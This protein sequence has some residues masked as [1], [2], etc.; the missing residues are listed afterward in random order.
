MSNDKKMG[1]Q[2]WVYIKE[3]VLVIE[4]KD[5]DLRG[6]VRLKG[7]LEALPEKRHG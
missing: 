6:V 7:I 5:L 4:E 1:M 2:A 3:D